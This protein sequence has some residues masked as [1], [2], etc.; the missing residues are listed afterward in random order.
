MAKPTMQ[1]TTFEIDKRIHELARKHGISLSGTA[2]RAI[3]AKVE[4]AEQ[5]EKELLQKDRR[6]EK[7]EYATLLPLE[8]DDII[9][10]S[11]CG[12]E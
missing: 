8:I 10:E 6:T 11:D 1:K 4:Q 12:E 9:L 5:L 7:K 3:S 2:R